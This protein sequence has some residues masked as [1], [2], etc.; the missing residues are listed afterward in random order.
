M[1]IT[2]GLAFC[3]LAGQ[4]Y[5]YIFNGERFLG[6]VKMFDLNAE[7]N[8]PTLFSGFLLF[9]SSILLEVITLAKQR[10]NNPYTPY[11]QSLSLIFLYLSLDELLGIHEKLNKGLNQILQSNP[12]KYWDVLNVTL[13]IVFGFAN[14][15]FLLHLPKNIQRLFILAFS[16]FAV[17]AVTI[18][19][20][21]VHYWT[22]IYGQ[23]IFLAEVITTFEECLEIL[24]VTIF[25]HAL[26]LYINSFTKD[27]HFN[28]V[29]SVNQ[30]LRS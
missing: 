2:L 4:I 11:W 6:L 20:I 30:N 13:L 28:I 25:I 9:L 21:G 16:L 17:G 26:I 1:F 14:I 23:K 18:E 3:S 24:G 8:I 12:D 19:L 27:I 5:I 10:E 22:N 7:Q 29:S 15:K